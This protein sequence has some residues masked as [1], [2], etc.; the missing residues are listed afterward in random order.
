MKQITKMVIGFMFTD[1][2]K[3]VLLLLKRHGP[4]SVVGRWNGIG[5]KIELTDADPMGA[6]IR[7]FEEETGIATT[8][9]DWFKFTEFRGDDFIVYCFWG[10]SSRA[11]LNARTMTDEPIEIVNCDMTGMRHIY[12]IPLAPNL[13]WWIPFLRDTS[14]RNHLCVVLANYLKDDK[15]D[16][17]TETTI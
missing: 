14:T 5:G 15:L 2:M 17:A 4:G 9:Q 12:N 13:K 8:R 10:T 11:V 1:D 7:E 6:Q 3:Q 16:A